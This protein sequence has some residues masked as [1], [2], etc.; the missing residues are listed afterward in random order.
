MQSGHRDKLT[1]RDCNLSASILGSKADTD[2]IMVSH[3]NTQ[4]PKRKTAA[5]SGQGTGH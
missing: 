5:G 2:T 3:T 1:N 4:L